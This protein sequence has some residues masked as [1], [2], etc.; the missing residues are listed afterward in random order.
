[1]IREVSFNLVEGDDRWR[2]EGGRCGRVKYAEGDVRAELPFEMGGGDVS[3]IIF[4]AQC[5]W[6]APETRAMTSDEVR[7]LSRELARSIGRIQIVYAARD[8]NET[9]EGKD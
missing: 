9:I 4:G 2:I 5:E 8:L 1:M 7:G 3:M 6:T